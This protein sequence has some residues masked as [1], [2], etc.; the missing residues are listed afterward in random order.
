MNG[1][2]TMKFLRDL[3]DATLHSSNETADKVIAIQKAVGIHHSCEDCLKNI[4]RLR[5]KS[6]INNG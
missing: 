3:G 6:R 4:D 1:T 2:E 5:K